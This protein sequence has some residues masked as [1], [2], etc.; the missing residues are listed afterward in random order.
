MA[1]VRRRDP[2]NSCTSRA[3]LKFAGGSVEHIYDPNWNYGAETDSPHRLL[4]VTVEDSTLRF[5]VDC[6]SPVAFPN[7]E[8][9]FSVRGEELWLFQAGLIEIYLRR[10]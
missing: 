6:P 7:Y 10:P 2:P 1:G 8:R 9:G 3:A 4:S 5:H